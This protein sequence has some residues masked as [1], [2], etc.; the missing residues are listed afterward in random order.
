[1]AVLAGNHRE[2][3]ARSGIDSERAAARGYETIDDRRRL[4]D[5]K[6]TPAGRN[7]PGMLV[8]LL[9]VRGSTWGYQYR[10]DMPRLR[11]DRLAKYETP[12]GQRNGLDVPA[13]V[14]DQLGDPSIPLFVTEGSKKADAAAARGLCCVALIGVY[15]WRGTNTMGGKVALADWNDVALNDRRVIM[16]YDGDVV[17]NP[18]VH[19]AMDAL[20]KYLA[21][22]GARVEFLHLPD[23]ETKTGLDDYVMA[24][25]VEEL[26]TLV[27][28]IAPRAR[29]DTRED[30]QQPEP[31]KEP[32]P[33]GSIDGAALLDDVRAWFARFICV[34][35]DGDYDILTLWAAHTYLAREL[36]TT[37]RLLITSP[38][39][40][41]GKTTLLEHLQRLCLNP[42]QAAVISS[43]ALLPRLLEQSIR[44]VLLDEVQRN[45]RKDKPGVQDL[46]SVIN[47]GYRFGATRPVLMPAGGGEWQS[48]EMSTFAPLAM[49]G[50]SPNLPD[51]TMSRT[52]QILMLPDIEDL[53]EESDWELVEPE[54]KM[55]A[56]R[57]TDWAESIRI[58][59]KDTSAIDLPAGCTRR[60]RERWKPLRRIAEIA[61]GNWPA[62]TDELIVRNLAEDAAARESGLRSRPP[63]MALL[64]DLHAV[65][66]VGEKFAAT[67]D[68]VSRL[69]RHDPGY[70]GVDSP[71]GKELTE[72]RFGRM[73]SGAAKVTSQRPGGSA[74]PRG[75]SRS[76]LEPTWRRLGFRETQEPETPPDQSDP[77]GQ[78]DQSGDQGFSG[79]EMAGDD[80][81][82]GHHFDRINRFDRLDSEVPHEG[83]VVDL[84][85]VESCCSD[86]DTEPT[87]PEAVNNGAAL[88]HCYAG[89][90]AVLT[91][92]DLAGNGYF[93]A[94]CANTETR[95]PK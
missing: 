63:A 21:I 52:L 62:V 89:C 9:D 85:A 30:R 95:S 26:W 22:K 48:R 72:H 23:T 91:A 33:F 86:S 15:G 65:W 37:P 11:G 68:L 74:S 60:V 35:D 47:S 87:M 58:A 57:L 2:A 93:C 71:Y 25:S 10:P 76:Q 55:L 80:K 42:I 64:A 84:D 77:S 90:G 4:A 27:K 38:I 34:V 49:A 6:I 44:T 8:P 46:E 81:T 14:G 66:P 40:E 39:H 32:P 3:L 70:W 5:L 94:G 12:T 1:M 36:Y 56:A 19:I 28:P 45:L 13:G 20:A 7:I 53:S 41:S 16:S 88:E 82:A 83:G 73:L 61:G 29:N 75:F 43:E 18:L 51:D 67:V 59:I 92:E 78:S 17:R 69:I 24:H 54:A 79:E 50:N 31:P